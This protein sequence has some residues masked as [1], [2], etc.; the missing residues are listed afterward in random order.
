MAKEGVHKVIKVKGR[1]MTFTGKDNKMIRKY[2]KLYDMK[3][4]DFVIGVLWSQI[5]RK[6]K[7]ELELKGVI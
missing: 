2:A 6:K 5:M 4:K 3:V 1:I 7:E